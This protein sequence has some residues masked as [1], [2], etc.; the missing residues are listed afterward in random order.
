MIIIYRLIIRIIIIILVSVI[1]PDGPLD[2]SDVSF[3]CLNSF[4]EEEEEEEEEKPGKTQ[5]LVCLIDKIGREI[6]EKN[7]N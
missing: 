1:L 5:L 2:C 4:D 6:S 3:C 7:Y